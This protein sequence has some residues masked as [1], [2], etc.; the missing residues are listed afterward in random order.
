MLL[1]QY[2]MIER[3]A[4]RVAVLEALVGK[5]RKTS[6]NS[7]IPPSKDDFGKGSGRGGKSKGV[8]VRRCGPLRFR[9]AGG[10]CNSIDKSPLSHAGDGVHTELSVAA[11]FGAN[12]I[13]WGD[14]F[15]ISVERLVDPQSLQLILGIKV[16]SIT[17]CRRQR[18]APFR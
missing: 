15:S 6:K 2:E 9:H 5:P 1:A 18:S 10:R 16:L 13:R 8:R 7:H 12:Y 4:A 11:I 17:I 14:N 3:L